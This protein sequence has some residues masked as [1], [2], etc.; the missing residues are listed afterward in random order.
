M[1]LI[2]SNEIFVSNDIRIKNPSVL[3]QHYAEQELR[4][5]NPEYYKKE[6]LG[7]YT[8]ATEKTIDLFV[9]DG[10]TL[11][12][13]FGV[14]ADIWKI[15]KNNNLP[16]T[17]KTDFAPTQE[18]NLTGQIDL[19]DYQERAVEALLKGKNGVLEGS[20]G[21]GKTQMGLA[22]IKR[23]G[24]RA[25]WLTHTQ[26]LLKQSKERCERYFKGD[27][28]TITEGHCTLGKDITFATVQTMAK[29]DPQVYANAF[30]VIVVDECHRASGTPTQVHQFYKVLSN[31]KARY[32]YGMSATLTRNDGLIK[33][34]FAIIGGKLHTITKEEIGDKTI[35]AEHVKVDIL[36]RYHLS[37]YCDTDGTLDYNKMINSICECDP[38]NK[39][40]ASNVIDQRMKG[41]KQLIL[42]ARVSHA[43][44]LEKLIPNSSIVVGN[45]PEKKRDYSANVLIAT[46]ALAK[47]GLDI[48]DLD[49]LHLA[50]PTK[51]KT[52]VVQSVG[53]IERNIPN[54]A[55]PVVFD[56]VDID[57]PYCENAF[58]KRKNIL[59]KH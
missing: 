38:R 11:V 48:P 16:Y 57:I 47:E 21:C 31:C 32:K 54:K 18:S 27:F 43:Y 50:T 52:T 10:D 20:C 23:L 59:R 5:D 4:L 1:S 25:L 44:A 40:I 42:T 45:I 17:I 53:R 2:Q 56:Y 28:G 33:S 46:Y 55:Q 51:D 34:V 12:L 24:L 8:G 39:R 3:I 36:W 14:F 7:Y 29:L 30:N 6:A 58:T 26:K 35:K 13:P 22:L 9:R 41:K 15:V 49:T 37:D 19:Y